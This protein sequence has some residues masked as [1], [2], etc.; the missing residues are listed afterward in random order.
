MRKSTKRAFTGFGLTLLFL[1]AF[2]IFFS[3]NFRTV[4]VAGE[5]MTPR[6]HDGQRVLVS[7]AYWLVGPIRHKD[8][9]V[10]RGE[11]AGEYLIKRVNRLAGEVVDM[12][13][14]PDDWPLTQ[15][16][17]R[18]PEGMIYVLGDNLLKS[19]D[20]RQLGPIALENVVGKVVVFRP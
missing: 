13:S 19:E 9:I 20:S 5:S 17:F 7:Q 6:F 12:A 4:V 10:L 16:E 11:E 1:L 3:L 14:I 8:V 2:S 15:G 18:V